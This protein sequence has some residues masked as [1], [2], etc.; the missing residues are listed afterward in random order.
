M[1]ISLFSVLT[2]LLFNKSHN[3]AIVNIGDAPRSTHSSAATTTRSAQAIVVWRI[4][5][6]RARPAAIIA[7]C[8]LEENIFNEVYSL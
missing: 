2:L 8:R 3:E 7:F 1:K 5:S 4:S 6:T